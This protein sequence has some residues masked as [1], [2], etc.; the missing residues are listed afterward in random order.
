[1]GV[2]KF[3]IEIKNMYFNNKLFIFKLK[4][5]VLLQQI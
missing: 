1:M 4:N 3:I 2:N 5:L